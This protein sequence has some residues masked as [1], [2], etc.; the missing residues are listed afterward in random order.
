MRVCDRAPSPPINFQPRS[1]WNET[2]ARHRTASAREG[3]SAATA[4]LL[5]RGDAAALQVKPVTVF[6]PCRTRCQ[7]RPDQWWSN[8]SL[9]GGLSITY[10]QVPVPLACS[11]N[12]ALVPSDETATL[13]R[14]GSPA[15]SLR[16]S[17]R[18][19]SARR[20]QR[21]GQRNSVRRHVGGSRRARAAYVWLLCW[22]M[23]LAFTRPCSGW[24]AQPGRWPTWSPRG[25]SGWR[26]PS[27]M[28][29]INRTTMSSMRVKPASSPT[30]P[31]RR[32]NRCSKCRCVG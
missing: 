6:A 24:T 3:G 18:S 14:P 4:A 12:A 26:S 13:T 17:G 27:R 29:R 19:G 5:G 32:A 28:A 11:A 16:R 2:A 20:Q 15:R 8:P 25:M 23:D 1:L 31:L 30:S 7:Q 22:K 10:Q 21:G 9:G